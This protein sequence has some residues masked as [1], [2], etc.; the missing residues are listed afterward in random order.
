MCL[1]DRW[2]GFEF[3][4]LPWVT[5]AVR[6]SDLARLLPGIL[7]SLHCGVRNICSTTAGTD[8]AGELFGWAGKRGL[9]DSQRL[10]N[11]AVK[12]QQGIKPS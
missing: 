6:V 1:K 7:D 2:N 4:S 3:S 9:Q 11:T 10:F 8:A 5:A 12:A